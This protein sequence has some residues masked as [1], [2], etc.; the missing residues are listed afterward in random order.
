MP[1]LALTSSRHICNA[2]S[3]ALPPPPSAPVWGM[4][5]PILIGCCAKTAADAARA[6][7]PKILAD[8]P[9]SLVLLLLLLLLRL[10]GHPRVQTVNYRPTHNRHATS[11]GVDQFLR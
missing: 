4:E 9:V 10:Y 1:P 5:T 2:S 7:R 11:I 6:S 8:A 3:A